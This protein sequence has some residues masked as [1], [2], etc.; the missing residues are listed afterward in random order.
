MAEHQHFRI[1]L[2]SPDDVRDE[3]DAARQLV[4]SSLSAEPFLAATA[5]FEIVAWD[6]P[7]SSVPMPAHLP[8]HDA[9]NRSLLKPSECDIVIVILWSKT[10]TPIGT[11][12][13]YEPGGSPCTGTLWEY[14]DAVSAARASGGKPIV[15][16]YRRTERPSILIDDPELDV[17]RTQFEAVQRFFERFRNPDGSHNGSYHSYGKA[18]DF[19]ELLRSHL[20][21]EIRRLL[22]P[23]LELSRAAT[24]P[25]FNGRIERFL[26]EYLKAETSAAPF[27]GRDAELARLDAWL[28]DTEDASRYLL[29]GPAGRGKSALV[30]RWIERLQR[31][32]MLAVPGDASGGWHLAFVPISIRFAT[33]NPV[34]FYQALAERLAAIAGKVLDKPPTDAANF[35]L[36]CSRDLLTALSATHQRVLVVLDG[37][38]EALRGDF[39]PAVFP[40]MLPP[41]IR[42]LATARWLAGDY[43]SSGWIKRLDWADGARHRSLE[44]GTLDHRAIGD[45][46]VKLGAPLDVVA[47][48][49]GLLTRLAELTNGEPLL[50]RFYALDLW[51]KGK[52]AAH[53]TRADLDSMKPGFTAYFDPMARI[54]APCV[55]RRPGACKRA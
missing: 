20:L 22:Q 28:A 12:P 41:G 53:I 31:R 35:Y 39:D 30:V 8:P 38:D 4:Q 25:A 2:S 49:P 9:V 13:G 11:S 46:L 19:P 15:L 6:M 50:V 14:E 24:A 32:G 34:V 33:N 26:D 40:R 21:Q 36:D 18:S 48:D 52:E 17:K 10:G 5:T 43:D 23:A 3:R 7:G 44:L 29:T 37:L 45:V 55:A 16:L 42:V 27:G 1:F 51:A 54:S 47:A